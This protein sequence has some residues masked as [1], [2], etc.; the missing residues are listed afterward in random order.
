MPDV[1]V[2]KKVKAK[3]VEEE[4][5]NT[6]E[7]K[8]AKSSGSKNRERRQRK[9]EKKMKKKGDALK[10]MGF[11][12]GDE[13]NHDSVWDEE[14]KAFEEELNSDA[15]LAAELKSIIGHK[16]KMSKEVISEEAANT[17]ENDSPTNTLTL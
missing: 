12:G 3:S 13:D 7:K 17:D 9:Q 8:K 1:V 6:E 10:R 16:I 5:A 14:R 11:D 15:E 4:A 2:V